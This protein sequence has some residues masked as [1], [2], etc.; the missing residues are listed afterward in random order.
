MTSGFLDGD[1]KKGSSRKRPEE[2]K[3]GD[4]E[5]GSACRFARSGDME[6]RGVPGAGEAR[7]RIGDSMRYNSVLY[8]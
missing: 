1:A 5:C 6:S 4:G 2:S 3:F 8:S 7:A